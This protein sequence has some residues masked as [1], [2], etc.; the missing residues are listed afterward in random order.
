M[1]AIVRDA[2][3]V[4]ATRDTGYR[5]VAAAL[6]EPIDNSLQATAKNVSIHVRENGPGSELSVGVLDDGRGMDVA[7][8]RIA[9]QFGGTQRFNDRSGP[10]R[11]GM[12]LPNSSLSHARRVDVYSWRRRGRVVH[13]YLD[14]DEIVLGRLREVPPPARCGLP[15]WAAALAADKG[16]LVI[17]SKCDRLQHRTAGRLATE[18]DSPLGRMFRYFLW[19]GASITVNGEPVRPVDPLF[20]VGKVAGGTEFGR[21]LTYQ[22]R[23]PTS[24]GETS[25]VRVRF[26]ELPIAKWHELPVSAKR[27]IGIVKGGGVSIVRAN[28][29]VAYGW[30]FMGSKRRE[31]YDDWWRCEIAFEPDLDEYFGMTHSKQGINPTPELERILSPDIEAVAHTLNSRARAEYARVRAAAPG[32]AAKTAAEKERQLA[33]INQGARPCRDTGGGSRRLDLDR[34]L[35]YRLAVASLEEESFY[36][37][38]LGKGELVLTINQEHPFFAR[39]YRPLQESASP[40]DRFAVECLLLALARVEAGAP[41]KAQRHWYRQGRHT[42]SNVLAAFLGG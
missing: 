34:R 18:L 16:T 35:K 9:L 41:S 42:L 4:V 33:P 39:I 14:V 19:G 29:E 2:N 36:S 27:Q 1:T 13:S 17:W 3:F 32:P 6:A 30:Y 5:S 22:I 11:F 21:P 40:R 23:V 10:G 24:S 8:L 20:L 15:S 12:G 38:R 25:L 7:T 26:S 28:R 31:N 37:F